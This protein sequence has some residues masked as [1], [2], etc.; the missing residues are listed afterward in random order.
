MKLSHGYP[1]T[2]QENKVCKLKKN[3]YGLKQSPPGLV[4]KVSQAIKK[5][6]MLSSE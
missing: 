2:Q 5:Y 1:I 4:W 3:L 6:R